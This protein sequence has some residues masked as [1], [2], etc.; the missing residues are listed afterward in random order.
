MT[1]LSEF[2]NQ[3][4]DAA[5]MPHVGPDPEPALAAPVM[6]APSM[7]DLPAPLPPPTGRMPFLEAPAEAEVEVEVADVVEEL[8]DEPAVQER[9]PD[10]P[11]GEITHLLRPL[12]SN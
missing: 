6:A 9:R 3:P 5:S 12:L 1:A 2:E 4:A 7:T 10:E 8:A 11:T